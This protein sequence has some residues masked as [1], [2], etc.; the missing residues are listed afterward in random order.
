MNSESQTKGQWTQRWN[1][2]LLY[3]FFFCIPYFTVHSLGRIFEWVYNRMALSATLKLIKRKQA[4]GAKKKLL[5]VDSRRGQWGRRGSE[6]RGCG[7]VLAGLGAWMTHSLCTLEVTHL[8]PG[9]S[10]HHK[11]IFLPR[12]PFSR[13]GNSQSSYLFSQPQWDGTWSEIILKNKL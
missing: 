12:L 8:L 11:V 7:Y 10:S 1:K 5:R 4:H 3:L 6:N 2:G 9:S 13:H